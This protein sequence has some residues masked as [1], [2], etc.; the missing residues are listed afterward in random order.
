MGISIKNP[1]AERLI[2]QLAELTGEGQTEAVTHAGQEKIDRVQSERSQRFARM[3]AIADR[4]APLLKDLPD[5][6]DYLYDKET[7]LPK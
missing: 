4:M 1:E 3:R 6:G 2:R 7:G 5:H